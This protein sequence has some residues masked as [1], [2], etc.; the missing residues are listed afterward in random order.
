MF[1]TM[2]PGGRGF[3]IIDLFECRTNEFHGTIE[4]LLFIPGLLGIFEDEELNEIVDPQR[5]LSVDLTSLYQGSILELTKGDL[6]I[7]R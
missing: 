4:P 7:R 3:R 2:P 6:Q 1:F 5:G